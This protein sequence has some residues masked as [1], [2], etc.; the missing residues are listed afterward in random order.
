MTQDTIH[1]RAQHSLKVATLTLP[2]ASKVAAV[3]SVAV[4]VAV[5]GVVGGGGR[6]TC[7]VSFPCHLVLLGWRGVS[8]LVTLCPHS[9]PTLG[10][11]S[12]RLRFFSFRFSVSFL[13][14][15]RL[16]PHFPTLRWVFLSLV[17]CEVV[18]LSSLFSL[19]SR[20]PLDLPVS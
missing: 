16:C 8:P 19:T 2:Q 12:L 17:D 10:W 1:Y 15:S 20:S 5:V 3:T 7:S 9:L 18:L 13:S 4:A 11:V 6:V 14:C